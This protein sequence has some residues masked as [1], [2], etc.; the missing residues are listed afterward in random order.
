MKSNKTILAE[1]CGI[2]AGDGWLSSY[3]NEVGYGTS[4]KEE[5]YFNF[6]INL[7]RTAFD[8][9]IFRILRRPGRNNTIELRIQSKEIQNQF[10]SWG[11]PRGPKL[12]NLKIPDF[13]KNNEKLEKIFL[14]GLV[15][16]DGSVHWRKNYKRKYITI[17]FATSSEKFMI[18]IKDLIIRLGYKP[19]VYSHQGKGNR[20]LA[21]KIQLQSMGDISKY[22]RTIGFDN[23]QRWLAVYS[24]LDWKRY[25]PAQIRTGDLHRSHLAGCEG[26][27]SKI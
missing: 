20:K 5:H 9:S 18:E 26:S 15:D 8:F 22:L 7:Y 24:N 13:I 3:N 23:K 19:T 12:E 2:H 21:W 10:I 1:I 17:T 25:G 27:A 11:F 14:R 6:V 4:I 16:T